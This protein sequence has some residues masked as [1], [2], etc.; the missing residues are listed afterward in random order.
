[1]HAILAEQA[2]ELSATAT[3][4][5]TDG[6]DLRAES[7]MHKHGTA[8]VAIRIAEP[9]MTTYNDLVEL[10]NAIG[11]QQVLSIYVSGAEKDPAKQKSWQIDLKNSLDEIE[12]SLKDKPHAEREAFAQGREAALQKLDEQG[13][14]SAPGWAGFFVGVRDYRAGPV[15]APVRTLAAWDVGPRLTPYVRALKEARPVI[16]ALVD[17]R[18]GLIY[19]YSDREVQL[20]ETVVALTP[21]EEPYHMGSAPSPGFRPGTVG[22][23]RTDEVQRELND[24]IR[25]MLSSVSEKISKIAADD[26]WIVLGGLKS[27]AHEAFERLPKKHAA[28][29]TIAEGVDMRATAA[30]VAELA[31]KSASELR[32]RLDLQLV[33]EAIDG[34]A[35][36]GLGAVGIRDIKPALEQGRVRDVYFTL[37]FLE[38]HPDD[39]ENAL[40]NALGTRAVVEHVSGDAALKLD[41]VGGIA[42]RLRY[43]LSEP[44]ATEA[45]RRGGTGD[46]A[47]LERVTQRAREAR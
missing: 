47:R 16:V 38:Q 24:A 34:A 42:A 25:R 12:A 9:F 31:R 36:R 40:R 23:T 2:A 43:T 14:A 22:S 30:T 18:Q 17:K 6:I 28:S 21:M 19:K 5:T 15:P 13:V 8:R 39:A 44:V 45:G 33:T 7:V 41:E 20:L 11:D 1:R 26:S 37:A 29:A 35:S 3:G 27:M 10:E 46:D 4:S 32:D